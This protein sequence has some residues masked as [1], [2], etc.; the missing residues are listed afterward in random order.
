MTDR[1]QIEAAR[2][3]FDKATPGKWWA[4]CSLPEAHSH[5][6]FS[7]SGEACVCTM[8]QNDPNDAYDSYDSMEDVVTHE[9]RQA[10]AVLIQAAPALMRRVEE[11]EAWQREA[12]EWLDRER[13]HK[14]LVLGRI[15]ISEKY[16]QVIII[17]E[18][19]KLEALIAQ[20][21]PEEVG[22]C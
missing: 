10:N 3:V 11:L 19:S 12:V 7:N 16:K 13:E 20:A 22:R 17:P 18:I 4:C 21:K 15:D 1:E 8:N 14:R 2:A 9:E 5:F 6:V